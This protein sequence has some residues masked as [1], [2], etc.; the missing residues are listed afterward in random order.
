MSRKP[1]S[2]MEKLSKLYD[3]LKILENRLRLLED[4]LP[5]PSR[6]EAIADVKAEILNKKIA[7]DDLR[8]ADL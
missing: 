8:E 3:D 7:I 2:S 5:A 1:N 6:D 4:L